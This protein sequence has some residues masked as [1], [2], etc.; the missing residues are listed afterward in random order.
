VDFHTGDV[1][2]LYTDG[3]TEAPNNAGQEFSG[4]RVA[5]ALRDLGELLPA[6]VNDGIIARMQRFT[7]TEQIHDDFTL[8]TV[9][10]I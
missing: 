8:V 2:V 7:G 6:A 9:R 5:E 10:R 3:L 4:E 1:F